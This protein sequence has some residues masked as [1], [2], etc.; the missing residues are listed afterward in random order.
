MFGISD[1][2]LKMYAHLSLLFGTLIVAPLLIIGSNQVLYTIPRSVIISHPLDVILP[3]SKAQLA[4][5]FCTPLVVI[6]ASHAHTPS[7]FE[8]EKSPFG[9]E[10][11]IAG[12]ATD[13][14]QPPPQDTGVTFVV[15]ENVLVTVPTTIFTDVIEL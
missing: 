13:P 3:P 11:T 9:H 6:C 1:V 12:A 10:S 15:T 5:I 14:P 7:V 4:V 8:L 2:A